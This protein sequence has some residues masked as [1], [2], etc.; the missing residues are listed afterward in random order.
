MDKNIRLTK[1]NISI[2]VPVYN[3][4]KYLV[5][6]LDSIFYQK[7]SGTLEVIAVNDGSTDG[8]LQILKSYR[9]KEDCL[10]IIN[11]GVNKK[12]SIARATG[13]NV[14]KGEYIM[15]VD[16]DDYLL[17]NALENLYAKCVETDADVVVFNYINENSKGESKL[18]NIIKTE[19]ISYDKVQIQSN[20]LGTCW[21]KI[22]K[23]SLTE[24]LISGQVGLNTTEDLLYATEILLKARKIC[25]TPKAYY[26]YFTNTKSLSVAIN[27]DQLIERQIIILKQIKIITLKYAATSQFTNNILSYLEKNM[28]RAI[29]QSAF[30][31]KGGSTQNNEL[32]NAFR[33]FPEMSN[34]RLNKLSLSMKNKYYSLIQV[35]IKFGVRHVLSIILRSFRMHNK[36]SQSL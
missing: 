12:L 30:L 9:K 10:A 25:L 26:V 16:S 8:S 21:N 36:K 11:H 17:P 35:F 29:A 20:F 5:R 24:S 14:S 4:E 34:K 23:R 18:V 13:M 22:V 3:V 19:H 1:P 7:F 32:I 15:H 2:I 33:S 27:P 28:H 6:C 31:V